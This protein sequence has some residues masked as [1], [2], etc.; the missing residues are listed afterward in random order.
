MDLWVPLTASECWQISVTF[1]AHCYQHNEPHETVP[2]RFY[3]LSDFGAVSHE[4]S[5]IDFT[6]R[7]MYLFLNY[8]FY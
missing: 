6:L 1:V 7:E 5:T 8:L 4:L 2:L 3:F